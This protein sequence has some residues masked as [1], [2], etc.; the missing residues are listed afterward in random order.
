MDAN[1]AESLD[2]TWLLDEVK[3]R[4]NKDAGRMAGYRACRAAYFGDRDGNQPPSVEG[5]DSAGRATLRVL[6]IRKELAGRV[7]APNL[8]TPIVDDY[9]YLRGS[10]PTNKVLPENEQDEAK[11]AANL[12]SK[13]I[14]AMWQ[15]SSM[16]VQQLQSAWQ[17]SCLGDSLYTLTPVF[18]SQVESF[19]PAGVYIT[20]HDPATAYP[21]FRTGWNRLEL[22][23]VLIVE[24]TTPEQ[25]ESEWNVQR[26]EEHTSE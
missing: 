24:E 1:S 7:G 3:R 14:R 12:R 6:E 16:D 4:K 23:D 25:A 11:E 17:L 13:I 20:V 2:L 15:N 21:Q 10:S 26:S 5:M 9:M 18:P 8:L 22:E 19:E